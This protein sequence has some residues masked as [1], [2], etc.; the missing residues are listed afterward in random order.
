MLGHDPLPRRNLSRE[1]LFEEPIYL[2]ATEAYLKRYLSGWDGGRTP[3][4]TDALS[5]MPL[6]CTTYQCALMEHVDRFLRAS[7]VT[8]QYVCAAGD[9]LT[10]L[11]LCRENA[12]AFFCPESYLLQ[13][14]FA[15]SRMPDQENRVLAM[16]IRHMESTIRVEVIC[17]AG[18]AIPRYMEAFREL[19][20]AEYRDRFEEFRAAA[21]DPMGKG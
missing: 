4:E 15:Q 8:V 13:S 2:L 7:G 18:H 6:A 11:K 21:K 10:L 17:R 1:T 19:L 14:E 9:Y 5:L 12:V 20:I 16:P 3:I